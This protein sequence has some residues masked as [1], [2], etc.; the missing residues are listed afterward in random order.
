MAKRKRLYWQLFIPY[1]LI[2]LLALIAIHLYS[3]NIL[4]EIL[5]EQTKTDL[6]SQ[7]VL[8]QEQIRGNLTPD[9]RTDDLCKTLGESL[10]TRFTVIL[11]NGRVVGDSDEDPS[12][13]DN[14]LD[15]HEVASAIEGRIG[16]ST[17]YGPTFGCF[18][19]NGVSFLRGTNVDA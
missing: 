13:M 10:P 7:A 16:I 6:R 17:R 12:R 4:E 3:S 11:P 18:F 14:H 19:R 9:Y 15:R 5:L 1:L 2:I 8:F